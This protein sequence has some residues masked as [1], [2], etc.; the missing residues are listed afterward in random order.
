MDM[1]QKCSERDDGTGETA[2]EVGLH[3]TGGVASYYY[4]MIIKVK[5]VIGLSV[6]SANLWS[7]LVGNV[8]WLIVD[9]LIKLVMKS[10]AAVCNLLESAKMVIDFTGHLPNFTPTEII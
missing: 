9:M 5:E 7:W 8:R 6:P 3:C 2:A 1:I 10:L 4:Y